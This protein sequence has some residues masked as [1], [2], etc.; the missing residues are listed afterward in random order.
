MTYCSKCQKT[1]EGDDSSAAYRLW[2]KYEERGKVSWR[3]PKCEEARR[4]FMRGF[5]IPEVYP[6]ERHR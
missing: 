3:C 6:S 4:A 1:C 2:I 5:D